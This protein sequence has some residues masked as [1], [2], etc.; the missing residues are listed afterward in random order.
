[1]NK[2]YSR[3]VVVGLSALG[4]VLVKIGLEKGWAAVTGENPPDVNDPE[5][6][7]VVA[8]SWAIASAAALAAL[9]IMTTRYAGKQN[10]KLNGKDR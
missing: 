8:L 4:G 3:L 10:L 7:I 9:Q 1:M 2:L 5:V 6:P